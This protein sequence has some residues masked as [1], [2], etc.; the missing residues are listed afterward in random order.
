MT[1]FA[2]ARR[3]M[4]DCQLRPFDITDHRLLAA[5]D[6]VERERFLPD[7]A[8]AV[9]YL[10]RLVDVGEGRR[11]LTPMTL[12]RLIQALALKGTEQVV[13]VACGLGYSTAVLARLAEK[14]TGVE[15]SAT[16]AQGASARLAASGVTNATVVQSA[17][18]QP[19]SLPGPV[20]AILING[21]VDVIPAAWASALKEGGRIAFIRADQ[22]GRAALAT[23][24]GG[25]LAERVLLDASAPAL[26][27]FARP[28]EFAF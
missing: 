28:V 17:L 13:D 18:G 15:S 19:P 25:A 10:D 20:D 12:A 16:L 4:V 9:A 27:E 24:I 14:V 26:P 7:E 6:E 11:L 3:Y 5:F 21:A 1:D 2:K 22:P 8:R 23:K